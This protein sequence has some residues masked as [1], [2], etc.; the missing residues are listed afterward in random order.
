MKWKHWGWLFFLLIP[1]FFTYACAM[2]TKKS[3][4]QRLVLQIQEKERERDLA[5]QKREDLQLQIA[6]KNDPSWIEMLLI[7]ELGVVPEG[8]LKIHFIPKNLSQ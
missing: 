5:L 1:L 3:Q 7:R 4:V 2:R 8:W 6:S